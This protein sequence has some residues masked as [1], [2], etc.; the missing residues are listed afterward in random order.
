MRFQ[1]FSFDWFSRHGILH[2]GLA[3][4]GK[5]CAAHFGKFV[6]YSELEQNPLVYAGYTDCLGI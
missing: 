5:F 4:L 6:I 3:V 2:I 1:N